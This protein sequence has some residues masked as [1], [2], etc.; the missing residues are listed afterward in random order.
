[1][2]RRNKAQGEVVANLVMLVAAV[3]LSS[4]IYF[5]ASSLL[6]QT[7]TLA[8]T[9]IFEN[10]AKISEQIR[11][12]DVYFTGTTITVYVRNFGDIPFRV[13]NAF[14]DDAAQTIS[15]NPLTVVAREP[16]SLSFTYSWSS[17]TTYRIRVATD[18]GNNFEKSYVAP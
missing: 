5:W 7:T 16:K 3:V 9:S 4:T 6:G 2:T 12:D 1:L 14:V 13:I 15:P 8:G 11:I 10:N 17:G 18:R